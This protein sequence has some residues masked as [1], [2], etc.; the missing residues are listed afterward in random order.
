MVIA[1]NLPALNTYKT[2]NITQKAGQ[3]SMEKLSSGYRINR[4]GD[5]A[6]GL[7]ISEKMR[8]QVRGLNQASRNAQDGISMIQ[9]GEGALNETHAILQRMR[10]LSVQS[11]TDTNADVDRE[12]LQNEINQLTSEVNRIGNT[13]EF[14]GM[15]LLDGSKSETNKVVSKAGGE[16]V[17]ITDGLDISNNSSLKGEGGLKF[18]TDGFTLTS[19]TENP[20]DS[21]S[22][23]ENQKIEI[24]KDG[25]TLKIKGEVKFAGT[26][27]EASSDTDISLK[28]DTTLK[29]DDNGD[30]VFDNHGM[31]FT[32][33]KEDFLNAEDGAKI[34]F[35]V[36]AAS[37]NAASKG[38]IDAEFDASSKANVQNIAMSGSD[39]FSIKGLKINES[40]IDIDLNSL[41]IEIVG[42]DSATDAGDILKIKI[43]ASGKDGESIIND[44]LS[45]KATAAGTAEGADVFTFSEHGLE[46]TINATD[47]TDTESSTLD[48]EDF[49]SLIKDKTVGFEVQEEKSTVKDSSSYFHVGANAD[50]TINMSI[51]DMRADAL[52]IVGSGGDEGFSKNN[53]VTNGTDKVNTE[54]A[55]DI[56]TRENAN[57]AI[58]VISSAIQ[59]VSDQRSKMGAV[60]NRLEYTINNLNTAAENMQASESRIRDVDM[61]K[62]MME[63]TKNNILQQA[64]QS[65]LVQ[66]NQTPQQAL[67]LL[68]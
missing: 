64:A 27:G 62:E 12:A 50:Q 68:R 40:G 49:S 67:Q 32:I 43:S 3:K 24:I 23:D 53:N 20:W 4:A 58:D 34:T 29:A 30:F 15:K 5:D 25:D 57:K 48:I 11:A 31:K 61:A 42:G 22:K 39:R 54:A 35:D 65:M 18:N 9:T 19:E 38:E 52:G 6:A 33:S 63:L 26:A 44:E 10:E 37:N 8:S 41:K 2:M 56:T 28:V 7:S 51:D 47:S 45:I 16:I 46:F 13:T 14:N 1:H 66:A 60:Q 36:T 55:L 21:V 17:K 59:K